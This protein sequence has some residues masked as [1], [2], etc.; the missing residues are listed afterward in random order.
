M[1]RFLLQMLFILIAKIFTL[2]T[3]FM[4]EKANI[5]IMPKFNFFLY[6][7]PPFCFVW[8]RIAKYLNRIQVKFAFHTIIFK[9]IANS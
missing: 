4:R 3:S 9:I 6:N 1:E 8:I 2:P 7:F 5:K